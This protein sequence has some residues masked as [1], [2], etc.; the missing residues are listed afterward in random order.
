MSGS[1]VLSAEGRSTGGGRP[2]ALLSA[3]APAASAEESRVRDATGELSEGRPTGGRPAAGALLAAAVA[4]GAAESLILATGE[5]AKALI[6]QTFR[7]SAQA[8]HGAGSVG[9]WCA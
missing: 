1:F 7:L 2:A 4:P 3:A 9:V 8:L 5:L 6:L